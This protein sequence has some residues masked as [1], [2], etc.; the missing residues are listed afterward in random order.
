MEQKIRDEA[1]R[2]RQA[3]ARGAGGEGD[4]DDDTGRARSAVAGGAAAGRAII[5][6]DSLAFS[7]GS[8]FMS[9]K[10]CVLP[11]GSYRC[12]IFCL[13]AH[14]CVCVF[15]P[16]VALPGRAVVQVFCVCTR[17]RPCATGPCCQRSLAFS[18]WAC[19]GSW[20]V[21]SSCHYRFALNPVLWFCCCRTTKKGYEEVHVPAL[22]PKPFEDGEW[23]QDVAVS[24]MPLWHS[25]LQYSWHYPWCP[26]VLP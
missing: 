10:A 3:E 26:C 20:L 18:H 12:V 14:A 17:A 24:L 19:C 9:K 11:P 4:A 1:R 6:L 25:L 5:D 21:S 16:C 7:Q 2:M 15:G 8:H 23:L 13:S 22:K